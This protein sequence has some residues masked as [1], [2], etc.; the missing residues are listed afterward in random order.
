MSLQ[1]T[2]SQNA[3]FR[4]LELINSGLDSPQMIPNPTQVARLDDETKDLK[5]ELIGIVR[6]LPK[7][8]AD[9]VCVQN[10]IIDFKVG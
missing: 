8:G 10:K 6:L 1:S 2:T 9:D 4:I 7:Y 5:K 3:S